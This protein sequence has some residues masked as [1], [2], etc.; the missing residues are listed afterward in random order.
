MLHAQ[1]LLQRQPEEGRDLV[2]KRIVDKGVHYVEED[3]RLPD[4]CFVLGGY[5]LIAFFT[6]SSSLCSIFAA[7]RLSS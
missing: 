6:M 1:E 3:D 7:S 4:H 5:L 2:T